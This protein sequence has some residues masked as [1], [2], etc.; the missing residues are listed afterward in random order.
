MAAYGWGTEN[1]VASWLFDEGHRFSFIQA[2][3]LLEMMQPER[4]SVGEGVDPAQEALRFRSSLSLAYPAS[5]V[6]EI[7]DPADP[8]VTVNFMSLG[9]C[10]G[11]LPLGYTERVLRRLQAGDTTLR[12]FLDIFHHRLVSLVYRVRRAH[13]IG[14]DT[15][16]PEESGFA[17]YLR[18]VMGLASDGLQGRLAIPDRALLRYAGLLGRY[19]RSTSVLAVMLADYFRVDVRD[20]QLQGA[21]VPLDEEQCTSI[22]LQG[23]NHALGQGAVLGSRVW[24]QQAGIGL[25]LGPLDWAEYRDFM[26]GQ[27]G[28]VAACQLSRF[29]IGPR[30]NID[31]RLRVRGAAVPRT[32]LSSD[33][34]GQLGWTAWLGGAGPTEL[35]DVDIA[36]IPRFA[37]APSFPFEVPQLA[38]DWPD[39]AA[40]WD[41]GLASQMT[42]VQ[43]L[44]LQD[45]EI[46][47]ELEDLPE[48]SEEMSE[49]D[50]FD[51]GWEAPPD[52][53]LESDGDSDEET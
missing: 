17:T 3:R 35:V 48:P 6:Q 13:R 47:E 16:S 32:R 36:Q 51:A 1:P 15:R 18:A 30:Y 20:R 43:D 31:L 41:G 34:G 42:P 22:G 37:D 2:V 12:D 40:E 44:V 21:Y 23:Q 7:T 19:P 10:L 14:I 25:E 27:P 39:D 28:F 38:G 9:G 26:P 33:F 53:V 11:P 50:L 8:V 52:D 45:G 29:Y 4:A 49:S 24:D 46:E 5:E